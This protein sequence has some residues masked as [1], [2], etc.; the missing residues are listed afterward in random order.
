MWEHFRNESRWIWDRC[1]RRFRC[2]LAFS[3][4]F[5]AVNLVIL[6]PVAAAILRFSL[7]LWGRASVGNFELARFFLSPAGL[8]ALLGVGTVLLAS[9]YFELSGLV[10]ILADDRL[11]WW[12]GLTGSARLLRRLVQLGLRQLAMYAAL[13]VPFL[14]GIA[15]AYWWFWQGRDL[16]GLIILKPPEFWWGAGCAAL[17]AAAYGVLALRLFLRQLHA[18]PI[19]T[20]ETGT[21]VPASL[22]ASAERTRGTG[23]RT[24]SALAAWAAILGTLSAVV[25][26]TL[27]FMSQ[28][29]LKQS[30]SS[31]ALAVLASGLALAIQALAAVLLSVL[32]N[33][34]FVGVVLSLYRQVAPGGTLPETTTIAPAKGELGGISRGR[35]LAVALSAAAALAVVVSV[36]TIR[37]LALHDRL[38]ITAHRAGATSAPENTVAAL[39]QAVADRAD[40]A[41]IDVQLTADKELV[42]MHDIDLARVGGGSRRVDQTTLA[43][44]QALDVGTAFGP[45]FAGERIPTLKEIVTAAGKRI[46]LNVELKPHGKTDALELTRRVIDELRQTQMLPRCRLCSQSYESLQL[47][48]QLEPRLEVGYIVATAVGDPTRLDVNFLMVKSNLATRRLVDRAALRGIAIHAWTVNDPAL[49]GPLLDAGVANVITDDP[50]RMRTQLEEIRALSPP[51]RLL[52]RAGNAIGR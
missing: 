18:V 46:R 34:S 15:A 35:I 47:A 2:A 8:A 40:W 12:E 22:R 16:N 24:A 14:V 41:E 20:L 10:Q 51:E 33:I 19:L 26:G 9:L 25:L 50:A 52:L 27:G 11:R 17:L 39:N 44:I 5:K 7:S 36:V 31:I 4:A 49:V 13:A 28:A 23:W 32:A 6:A 45:K 42:I 21:T 37:G 48:R 1:R 38:E 43:E 29:I 30:G 3:L